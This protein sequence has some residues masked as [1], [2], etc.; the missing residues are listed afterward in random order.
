MRPV[1]A[2]LTSIV[3]AAGCARGELAQPTPV[4]PKPLLDRTQALELAKAAAKEQGFDLSKHRLSTFGDETMGG[5]S[6]F[7]FDFL[8]MP[9]GPP[10]CGFLA[11]VDRRTG[12]VEI[13]RGL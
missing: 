4:A 6:E 11:V 13:L 1:R 2:F 8:C 3:L 5:D 7:G 12:T 9:I 10:G